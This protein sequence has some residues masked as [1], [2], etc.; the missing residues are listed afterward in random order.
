MID[1]HRLATIEAVQ[2][3][4]SQADGTDERAFVF[5][6]ARIGVMG[7]YGTR[8]RPCLERAEQLGNHILRW[9][10]VM[11]H[12]QHVAASH[13][14]CPF[15]TAILCMGNAH[16]LSQGDAM[17]LA[18]RPLSS[19]IQNLRSGTVVHHYDGMHLWQQRGK[20]LGVR[21]GARLHIRLQ[22]H[23]YVVTL[24]AEAICPACEA[25]NRT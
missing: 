22:R 13:G 14:P 3:D 21:H 18:R 7:T 23:N 6:S 15:D 20:L 2:L 8:M 12:E 10:T 19:P 17:H 11:I 24:P 9:N 1:L 4:P 5:A 25:K 16:V